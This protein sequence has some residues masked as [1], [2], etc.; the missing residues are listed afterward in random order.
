MAVAAMVVIVVTRSQTRL[1][2]TG[3]VCGHQPV[4]SSAAV[5]VVLVLEYLYPA[6]LAVL[7]VYLDVCACDVVAARYGA[8]YLIPPLTCDS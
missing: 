7:R 3:Q 8:R 2:V 6:R 4:G 5:V 1:D